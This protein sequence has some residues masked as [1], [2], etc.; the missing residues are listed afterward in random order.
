MRLG[1]EMR[2]VEGYFVKFGIFFLEFKKWFLDFMFFRY[3]FFIGGSKEE[4]VFL[5][6][7]YFFFL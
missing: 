5:L 4:G 3:F 7:K 6:R 2:F 1:G